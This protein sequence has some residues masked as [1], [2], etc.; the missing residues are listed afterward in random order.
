M[1]WK[2]VTIIIETTFFLP[3]PSF[4]NRAFFPS[5]TSMRNAQTY[6]SAPGVFCPLFSLFPVFSVW[7]EDFWRKL[8]SHR[9]SFQDQFPK[10]PNR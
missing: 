10:P 4:H 9:D 8:P 6:C 1:R 3:P 5:F 2:A 7:R